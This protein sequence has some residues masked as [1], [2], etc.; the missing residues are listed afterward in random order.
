MEDTSSANYITLDVD[1]VSSEDLSPLASYLD[2]ETFILGHQ[3]VEGLFYLSFEPSLLSRDL[4]TPESSANL[5]LDVLQDLPAELSNLWK[6]ASSKAFNFGFE[7][8]ATAPPYISELKPDTLRKI[9]DLGASIAITIYQHDS[10]PPES[11]E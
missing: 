7:S 6:R 2:K 3:Q 4:N 5:I 10:S 1:L 8:G 9:A 11:I